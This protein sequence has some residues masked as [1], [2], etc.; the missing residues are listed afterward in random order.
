MSTLVLTRSEVVA[1][2]EP[3]H[4]LDA[5][6][7]GFVPALNANVAPQRARSA[8][9]QNGTTA[10]VL[11]PDLLPGIP[12]YSVKVHPK[13][14][15]QTPAIRGLIHLFDLE[16]GTLLAVMDSG[17]PTALRTAAAGAVAAHRGGG[18]ERVAVGVVGARPAPPYRHRLRHRAA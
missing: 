11:F 3:T 18:A 1:T 6:R 13:F 10:T 8:L 16:T 5:I 2:L 7:E 15:D 17:Y 14:P 12:V 9:P 4:L